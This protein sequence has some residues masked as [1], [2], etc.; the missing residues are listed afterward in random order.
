MIKKYKSQYYKHKIKFIVLTLLI[1]LISLP[2]TCFAQDSSTPNVAP[3][4]IRESQKTLYN[5]PVAGCKAVYVVEPTTGKVIFEKNAHEKMYPASTTKILTALLAIENCKLDEIAIVSQN[6]V[7]SIPEGYS[8]AK[9]VAGEKHTIKTLLCA[10]LIP[11]ANEAAN[12]IA[13]HISRKY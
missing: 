11:S 6:A 4:Y 10:L 5:T 8:D 1:C 7:G 9:L 2:V 3:K 12:V 13:E